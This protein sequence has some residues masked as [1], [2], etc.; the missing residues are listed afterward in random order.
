VV[1]AGREPASR[2]ARRPSRPP[3]A[4]ARQPARLLR[5]R[6]RNH[7]D[8]WFVRGPPSVRRRSPVAVYR[9]I[10]EDELLGDEHGA[11][12]D[13]SP[14]PSL[15][16]VEPAGPHPIMRGPR[17]LAF[18]TGWTSTALMVAVLACAAALLL[19]LSSRRSAT[20]PTPARVGASSTRPKTPGAAGAPPAIRS[21]RR[22][23]S[24]RAGLPLRPAVRGTANPRRLAVG[25]GLSPRQT[26]AGP[27]AGRRAS[28]HA[29]RHPALSSPPALAAPPAAEPVDS[30][31]PEQ[32]FGFER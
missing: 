19:N 11:W 13:E 27:S 3:S 25:R 7:P 8:P 14:R 32:E 20:A 31:G 10:D 6:C 16:A 30:A 28:A 5:R 2:H 12:A 4:V 9:V 15:A 23:P 22:A 29:G 26:A 17:R 24:S 18:P 21:P 1:G